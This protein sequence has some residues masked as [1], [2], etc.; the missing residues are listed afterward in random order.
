MQSSEM[1]R[2]RGRRGEGVTV[3]TVRELIGALGGAKA[4]RRWAGLDGPQHAR[5]LGIWRKFG[6][7]PAYHLRLV[8]EAERRGI[9]LA[10]QVLGLEYSPEDFETYSAKCVPC[11]AARGQSVA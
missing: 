11:P 3:H 9:Q 4:F 10:P 7:P 6:I 8:L 1:A 2:R 5:T